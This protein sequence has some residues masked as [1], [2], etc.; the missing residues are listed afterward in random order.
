MRL[1]P[2]ILLNLPNGRLSAITEKIGEEL[3][4]FPYLQI[5]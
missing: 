1:I 3:A 2:V 4:P 5:T